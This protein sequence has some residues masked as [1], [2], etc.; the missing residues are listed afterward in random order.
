MDKEKELLLLSHFRRNARE[1]LTRI[2]RSTRVPVSTVFDK[3]REY[4][5][6]VISKHTC[7]LDFKKLGFDLKAS[8]LFKVEKNMRDSFQQFLINHQ[9][10]NNV[11]RINNGFDFLIEAVFYNLK[12]MD[13]F[14]DEADQKGAMERKEFFILENLAQENFLSYQ[15]GFEQLIPTIQGCRR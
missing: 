9:R 1:S 6:N 3:L 12:D 4:E 5:N 2:S 11:F 14:F 15:P 10:T 7:I 8:I 13:M